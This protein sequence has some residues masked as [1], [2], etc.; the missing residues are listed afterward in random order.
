MLNFFDEL[1]DRRMLADTA[2][3]VTMRGLKR[4]GLLNGQCLVGG[5]KGSVKI[6]V[7]FNNSCLFAKTTRIL[8]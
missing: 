1:K 2:K 3:M 4:L 7:H 6:F 8:S 5:G